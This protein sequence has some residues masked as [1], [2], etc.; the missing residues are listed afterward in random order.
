MYRV[1]RAVFK[2]FIPSNTKIIRNA[3]I[4]SGKPTIY[5][6]TH[7]IYNDVPIFLAHL[8]QH[9]Y[10]LLAIE[11]YE[12]SPS[13][14]EHFVLWLYGVIIVRR[15]NKE[16]R[17]TAFEKMVR[18]IKNNGS[19]LLFPEGLINFSPNMLIQPINWGAV[20]LASATGANLVPAAINETE[21]TH[22]IIIDEPFNYT[23]YTDLQQAT[24]GL[25]DVMAT[26]IYELIKMTTQINRTEVT[27][28]MWLSH[29]H[30]QYKHRKVFD[31]GLEETFLYRPK[32]ETNLSE[33]LADLYGISHASFAADY[34][35]YKRIQKLIE[36][37]NRI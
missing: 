33:V 11:S 17:K 18:V 32:G 20:K 4:P 37:W 16:S 8:P 31:Q 12:N 23:D 29:I 24:T 3:Y 13:R 22:Q 35:Q 21:T 19:I 2:A 34:S 9:A 10:L 7:V 6:A 28:E 26:L 14:L 5:A 1:M 36:K 25:R 15:D 27:D 30:K